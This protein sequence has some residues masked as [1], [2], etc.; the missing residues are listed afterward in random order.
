M[1]LESDK[2]NQ[3]KTEISKCAEIKTMPNFIGRITPHENHTLFEY[4]IKT[5]TLSKA[6]F[7]KQDYIFSG[8]NDDGLI[9]VSVL[10]KE[11]IVKEDCI[12]HSYLNKKNAIKG[13]SKMLKKEINPTYK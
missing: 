13:F 9:E 5:N 10:K 3:D 12:Y 11:V 1:R 7:N 4:N 2:I 6:S 8:I